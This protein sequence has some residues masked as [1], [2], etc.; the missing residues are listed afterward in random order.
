MDD[1]M[2]DLMDGECE[3][4]LLRRI[5]E[6]TLA[7]VVMLDERLRY[8]Y[9][10][11]AWVRVSGVPA[12]AYLGRPLGEVL[13]DVSWPD[14]VLL[15]V[16]ED[17]QPREATFTGTT[18]VPSHLGRRLWRGVFHRLKT[19]DRG[20]AVCGI[21]VEVSNLGRYLD[22]LENAHQRLA[23]LDL[24]ATRI[25]TTLDIE[26]TCTELA[27]FLAPSMADV[28]AVGTVEDEFCGTPAPG[29]LRLRKT[30]LS[31]PQELRWHLRHLGGPDEYLDLPRTSVTRRCMDTGR[32]WLG[33][34]ATDELIEKVTVDPERVRIFR[35]AGVH[36]VLVVPLPTAGRCVGVVILGRA[37]ASAPFSED[38]VVTAQ[39]LAGRAAVAIDSARRY[40]REH[41]M[42]LELQR[43]LLSEPGSPHAGVEVATRYLPSGRSALVGGDWY[44]S[45]ALPGGRTLLVMGDVMGHGFQAA[46]T[47]SQ[48]RSLLRTVA[49]SD[50]PVDDILGE[51]DRR[52]AHIG[53]DRV[54]TCLL[55][56]MD[57]Q[58][59]ICTAA[60]AGHLPPLAVHP[61]G[62]S[63][64]L[65]LPAG[66]PLGAELGDYESVTVPT[67]PG[68]VLLLYTD[69]LVEQRG[70]DIDTR[71]RALTELQLP[72][73]SPLEAMLDALL[74]RLAHGAHEDDVALLAARQRPN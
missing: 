66:P 72:T 45:L 13:P 46:V 26:T 3:C 14:D 5:I 16:L 2:D 61:G 11:P 55:V 17:G 57:P 39:G 70:T 49:A 34:L 28:A 58:A 65:W 15:K 25:G 33:N 29:M 59:G 69:G 71:L 21:G 44:D 10:N 40:T 20:L 9:V 41:T 53:L 74:A 67:E 23:L 62:T 37:G 50:M 24:A 43:A 7:P 38:D 47:M 63:E 36:S 30:A 35:A 73:E 54:A 31:A 68:T 1:L 22:D 42:A 8:L 48:Y 6:E 56:L 60:S 4:G 18:R 12:A 32:P 19:R 27:D 52:V 51:V 64:M